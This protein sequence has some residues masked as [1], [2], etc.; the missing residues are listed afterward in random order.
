MNILCAH[1]FLA[2][3]LLSL[4]SAMPAVLWA[5]EPV[6][7][8]A[9]AKQ[10]AGLW[11]DLGSSERPRIAPAVLK[12][13]ARGDSAAAFL[14]GK[15]QVREV[16]VDAKRVAELI[17]ELDANDWRR[18]EEAQK[19]LAKIGQP[20]VPFLRKELKKKPSAEVQAR[21]R[22]ILAELAVQSADSPAVLR[23]RWALVVLSGIASTRALQALKAMQAGP[24][25][26]SQ[27]ALSSA[28]LNIAERRLPP[29]LDA[30]GAKA[31]ESDRAAAAKL[32][33]EALAIAK[34][35][36][37]YS[38]GRIDAILAR[39]RANAGGGEAGAPE[40]S[41]S[42]AWVRGENL[43]DNCDF[44]VQRV[45]GIWPIAA[46]VWGGDMS[47]VLAAH[48]GVR[49]RSG[50]SMLR[51]HHANF[52]SSS[53]GA[54]AQLFQIV[55]IS[56]FRDAIAAGRARA[57]A[58][59]FY[60]RI[61]GDAKTDTAFSMSLIAYSGQP[62][63][64]FALALANSARAR[65]YAAIHTDANPATWQKLATSMALPKKTTFLVI[66]LAAEENMFNDLKGVEFH[67]HYADDAFVTLVED[68]PREAGS[69]E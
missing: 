64:H 54:G 62:R 27:P 58:S 31:K 39:L 3:A 42:W 15:L 1:R 12:L 63:Q 68:P 60:N 43:V 37:H 26:D 66:Q 67:G 7:S 40:R 69:G 57:F 53:A 19:E 30:A 51:F 24:T 4:C 17:K 23:R 36:Q 6:G 29:L 65:S 44:E 49:P 18:R 21:L 47:E 38:A 28:L 59:V 35:T 14:A 45:L 52:R 33:A 11:E 32:C 41:I 2:T 56:K 5:A 8:A 25:G 22:A 10:L 61:A 55:D 13:I 34:E 46:G 20:V 50:K 16:A 9:E 48:Q